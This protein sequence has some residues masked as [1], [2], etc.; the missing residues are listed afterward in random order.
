[1]DTDGYHK[2]Y[3]NF[4]HARH[5][6]AKDWHRVP[7]GGWQRSNGGSTRASATHLPPCGNWRSAGGKRL[8]LVQQIVYI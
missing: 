7:N 2:P 3:G 1:M 6:L 4:H 5:H 8:R